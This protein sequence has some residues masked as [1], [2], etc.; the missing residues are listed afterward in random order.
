MNWLFAWAKDVLEKHPCSGN[1]EDEWDS[2]EP[3]DVVMLAEA[4]EELKKE[5]IRLTREIVK[6]SIPGSERQRMNQEILDELE[7]E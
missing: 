2:I 6:A 1:I 5:L 7:K 3:V 4:V